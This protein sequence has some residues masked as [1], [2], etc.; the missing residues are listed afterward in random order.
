MGSGSD[1]P[2]A[3]SLVVWLA[4]IFHVSEG[5]KV[6]VEA[7]VFNEILLEICMYTDDQ[8][9]A[10]VQPCGHSLHP[11]ACTFA[12]QGHSCF[13]FAVTHLFHLLGSI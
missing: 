11:P 5:L 7:L 6:A 2:G 10:M 4:L 9:S 3:P 12:T 8:V 13:L 1:V